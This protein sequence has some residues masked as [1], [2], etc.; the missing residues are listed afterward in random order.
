MKYCEHCKMLMGEERRCSYCG[1][2]LREAT[3]EDYCLLSEMSASDGATYQDI[4]Q[5]QN[6]PCVLVPRRSVVEAKLAI[7]ASRYLVY[8]PF[9]HYEASKSLIRVAEEAE[10]D[11]LLE[12]LLLGGL[13]RLHIVNE[14]KEKKWRKKLGLSAEENFFDAVKDKIVHCRRIEDG[15]RIAECKQGG[16]MW[17]IYAEG[18]VITLNN[19]TCEIISII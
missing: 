9:A 15:G 17:F 6:I 12:A 8:V 7:E 4:F 10:R 11:R 5:E 3:P 16:R 18:S 2:K 13:D 14:R 19:A 1:K